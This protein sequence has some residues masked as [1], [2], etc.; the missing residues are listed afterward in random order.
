M[1]VL[2]TFEIRVDDQPPG[3]VIRRVHAALEAAGGG[4][5]PRRIWFD[6]PGARG[7]AICRR[8]LEAAPVLAP[9]AQ[10]S[11]LVRMSSFD[12]HVGAGTP[13]CQPDAASLERIAD[14][15]PVSL[16]FRWAIFIYG[17]VPAL[18]LCSAPAPV[19]RR[20]GGGCAPP[21]PAACGR[22][23]AGA[24]ARRGRSGGPGATPPAPPHDAAT[25]PPLPP[26]T[27]QLV[28]ALGK[29]T[30]RT[31]QLL[32]DADELAREEAVSRRLEPVINALR[33]RIGAGPSVIFPHHLV[34]DTGDGGPG[35]LKDIV[36]ERLRPLG[37]RYISK[38]SRRGVWIF[39][40]RTAAHNEL[41]VHIDRGPMGGRVFAVLS[42]AG[43]LWSNGLRVPL[44][45]GRDEIIVRSEDICRR[46]ADNL[47]F[48][49]ERLEPELLALVEPERP[50]GRAW[51]SAVAS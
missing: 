25:L 47:A 32:G 21:R 43:P 39:T 27:R 38:A 7:P 48:S 13:V 17:P 15:I 28:D 51:Y 31:Q 46:L 24:P 6:A 44:V 41:E 42:V 50:P 19:L 1:R 16:P 23:R 3:T 14:D 8:A 49:I 11:P 45:P 22:P 30:R 9:T 20:E 18:Q 29:V 37:F 33:V 35:P 36:G 26:R 40:K 10:G 2:Q 5:A 4:D 12:E 34:D